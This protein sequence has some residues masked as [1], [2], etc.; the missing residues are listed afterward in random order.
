MNVMS[1][2]RLRYPLVVTDDG[3]LA[4]IRSDAEAVVQC[5]DL[6][7]DLSRGDFPSI[8]H[9][10]DPC[11]YVE[12]GPRDE[13]EDRLDDLAQ[14]LDEMLKHLGLADVETSVEILEKPHRHVA[15]LKIEAPAW[16]LIIPVV[17]QDS[18]ILQLDAAII[19]SPEHP[20][21]SKDPL[22]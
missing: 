10:A 2:P 12:A 8:P 14:R 5:L 18:L 1:Q 6:A 13:L 17:E 7:R 20:T 22:P 11:D 4:T 16:K 21:R 19:H 3:R 15:E 9:L